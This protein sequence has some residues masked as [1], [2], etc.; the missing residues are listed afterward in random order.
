MKILFSHT[1]RVYK[2][3]HGKESVVAEAED[4]S[5][6]FIDEDEYWCHVS[7]LFVLSSIV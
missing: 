1:V 7:F 6:E 4:G 2:V 3:H 5:S